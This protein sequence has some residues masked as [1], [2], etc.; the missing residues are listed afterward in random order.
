MTE[1]KSGLP[2]TAEDALA[3]WDAGE[4][5][6]AFHVES[7]GASQEAIYA[8]AFELLR[9]FSVLAGNVAFGTLASSNFAADCA[10]H[11]LTDREVDAAHSIAYVAALKGWI[12]MIRQHVGTHIQAISVTKPQEQQ[13]GE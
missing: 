7:E 11:G 4:P 12:A 9:D 10:K 6:P 13:A 1:L 2:K 8:C 3:L 5:V